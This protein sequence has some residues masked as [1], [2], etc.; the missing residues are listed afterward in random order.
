MQAETKVTSNIIATT[1]E[2]VLINEMVATETA[3]EVTTNHLVDLERMAREQI[4]ASFEANESVAIREVPITK[5]DEGSTKVVPS[6][7]IVI[8][9]IVSA[10]VPTLPTVLA[11]ASPVIEAEPIVTTPSASITV[12]ETSFLPI[13]K[14]D[15]SLEA[16][17]VDEPGQAEFT[18]SIHSDNTMEVTTTNSEPTVWDQSSN[19]I[20]ERTEDAV[21]DIITSDDVEIVAE[22]VAVENQQAEAILDDETMATFYQLMDLLEVGSEDSSVLPEE[23][24]G[25]ADAS[26]LV[27]DVVEIEN[28]F[29]VFVAN[30]IVETEAERE[31]EIGAPANLETIVAEANEQPLTETFAQL[32][33]YLAE[34]EPVDTEASKE[35]ISVIK[36]LL[37]E[38]DAEFLD[39]VPLDQ[40]AEQPRITPEL[41]QKLLQLLSAVGYEDP[42]KTL[43]EFVRYHD[44]EFLIQA[45]RHLHQLANDDNRQGL[46]ARSF[47]SN[48]ADSVTSRL[49]Q[50]IFA[51]I[52]IKPAVGSF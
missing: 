12:L 3:S 48:N 26:L 20:V 17:T 40:N 51:L 18:E 21:A 11:V 13:I 5:Q 44:F 28:S 36:Q 19:L 39:L 52:K 2:E 47:T 34:P 27:A 1:P 14:A 16:A 38:I 37:E 43:V 33:I 49:G 10:Q 31:T 30:Y 6:A 25:L 7:P 35:K 22:A 41:T 9:E 46:L 8:E 15:E 45:T 4:M 23:E 32:A 24:P 42:P 29:E 50:A